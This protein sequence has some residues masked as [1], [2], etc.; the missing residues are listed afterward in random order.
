MAGLGATTGSMTFA[1]STPVAAV[2]GFLNYVPGTGASIS[3]YDINH[4]LIESANLT[5]VTGGGTG[6]GAFY[7][8]REDTNNIAYFTLTNR[9]IG[10]TDLTTFT[11]APVPIPPSAL[12]LGS[13]LLGLVGL[14]RWR[15]S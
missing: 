9:Y 13:G 1:F 15:R 4:T 7:G 5:F 12:L 14:R 3:V 8:F 6:A 11:A 2:G 10:I